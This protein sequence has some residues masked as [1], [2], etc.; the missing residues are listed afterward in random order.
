MLGRPVVDEPPAD[1][2]PAAGAFPAA[3]PHR[4]SATVFATPALALVR[5]PAGSEAGVRT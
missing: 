2:L 1:A 4:P 3:V 5:V